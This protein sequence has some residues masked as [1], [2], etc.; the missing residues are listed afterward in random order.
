MF[1]LWLLVGLS[2]SYLRYG[3]DEAL[4]D[5]NTHEKGGFLATNGPL[6]LNLYGFFVILALEKDSSLK[7][8]FF[9]A[10]LLELPPW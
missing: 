4:G 2:G 9:C 8:S 3:D 7:T 10:R 1:L 5:L 6:R